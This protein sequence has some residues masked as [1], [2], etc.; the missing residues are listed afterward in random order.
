MDRNLHDFAALQPT[1]VPDEGGDKAFDDE[2]L[3]T[4]PSLPGAPGDRARPSGVAPMRRALLAL[5]LALAAGLMAGC[6]SVM[7]IDSDVT[8]FPQWPAQAPQAG[9]RFAF[10]R[11]PSQQGSQPPRGQDMLE[12][13]VGDA[14]QAWG[15]R[16]PQGEEPVR[17]L[18]QVGAQGQRLPRAPWDPDPGRAG[19]FRALSAGRHGGAA[20]GFKLLP[21]DN[22]TT[23]E[24]SP[25]WC[26]RPPPAAWPTR[27]APARWP[28]ERQP[29]P[30]GRH[31]PRPRCATFR[32]RLRAGTR[33]VD[34][35]IPR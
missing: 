6:A 30:V 18:V 13:A 5:I 10:E 22:P 14:L 29:G 1:G 3:P 7:R 25:S 24:R 26:A 21:M 19:A 33:R 9:D 20:L 23:C 28:L 32:S 35:D 16:L 27:P 15:L 4:A 8:S 17:W 12:R 34:I 11:L 2:P 31:G